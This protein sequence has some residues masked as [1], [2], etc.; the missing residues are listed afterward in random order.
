MP[1]AILN[2]F[3][4]RGRGQLVRYVLVDCMPETWTD[5]LVPLASVQEAWIGDRKK[6]ESFSGLFGTLPVLVWKEDGEE[7]LRVSQ[8][9]VI[10]QFLGRKLGLYGPEGWNNVR[11]ATRIDELLSAA[12]TDLV[13]QTNMALWQG[14][15]DVVIGK[16]QELLDRLDRYL[17]VKW[18]EWKTSSGYFVF[19]ET[20]TIA[21]YVMFAALELGKNL[22]PALIAKFKHLDQFEQMF[23]DRHPRIQQFLNSDKCLSRFTGSPNEVD[24]V[25]I[26]QQRF[27]LST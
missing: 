22:M 20:A 11:I 17:S 4:C 24:N 27:A 21:D 2:Y 7:D 23:R 10:L 13:F 14:P 9:M 1:R 25:K 19:A 18:A 12:Y 15:S 26:L 8:T 5:A 6:D 16:L 3:D